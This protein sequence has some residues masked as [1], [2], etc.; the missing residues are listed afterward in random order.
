MCSPFEVYVNGTCMECMVEDCGLCNVED[1]YECDIC[2][3][4]YVVNEDG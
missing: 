2:K 4:G 1:P 3:Y